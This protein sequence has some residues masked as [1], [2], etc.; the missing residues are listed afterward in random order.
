MYGCNKLYCEH[1]GRYYSSHYRQLAVEPELYGVDFRSVRFPG[2]ISAVTMPSGSTSDYAPEMLHAAAK[3]EPYASFVRPD[4][5]IPFMVMPDAIKALLSLSDAPRE[6]L[7]QSVYNVSSFS[8]SAQEI[9]AIVKEAFPA[10]Q[11]TYEP[12][13]GRQNI[14]D[15]WPEDIDDSAARRDW[16]WHPE[17]D[18]A[19]AFKE[20]LIPTIQQHYQN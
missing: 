1:V 12:T 11:V 18:A 19:R 6:Q 4:T 14:V 5:R 17:Y 8:L 3:G 2:L 13:H 9:E 10:A 7:K 15:S 16:Q 20:Y